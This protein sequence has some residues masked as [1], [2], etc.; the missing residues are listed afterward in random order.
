MDALESV[1][2]SLVPYSLFAIGL[3]LTIGAAAIVALL[4][5]EVWR[6]LIGSFDGAQPRV[7]WYLSRSSA[8]V[9]YVLLWASMVLGLAITNRLAR[10]WPGGPT[11]SALHEHTGLLALAL[12]L[13]HALA[14]LGDRYIG[15]TLPQVLVPFASLDYRP[16]WVAF[17]QVSF[18]LLIP[19]SLTF[20]IRR[21]IGQATWRRI[22][23]LNFAV[24]GLSLIHG[25][26][27]GTDSAAFPIWMMYWA[28]F[29]S[30]AGLGLYRMFRAVMRQSVRAGGADK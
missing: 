7:F 8:L 11:F 9:S 25:L 26:L 16:V 28:S 20:Y 14:L 30:V 29:V 2:L 27:S 6:S 24:F 18:Y 4:F 12:A 22:H 10:V 21:W 17:G 5:P 3:A 15:Y 13:F 23:Y 19:A 1:A